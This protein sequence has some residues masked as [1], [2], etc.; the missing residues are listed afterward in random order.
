[1]SNVTQVVRA[2][3]PRHWHVYIFFDA[4]SPNHAPASYALALDPENAS[5]APAIWRGSRDA[6]RPRTWLS[7]NAAATWAKRH[8]GEKAF[9]RQCYLPCC[10]QPSPSGRETGKFSV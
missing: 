1:M 10:Y 4:P 5:A 8:Y 6:N 2:D 3:P 7:R 9:A